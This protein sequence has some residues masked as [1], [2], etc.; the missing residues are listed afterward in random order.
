MTIILSGGGDPE[1]V[2]PIDQY[3]ADKIDWQKPVLY[4]PVA[5]EAS[6]FSYDECFEWF[7][8]TYGKYGISH[9]AMC[10][11]LST[12]QL[13]S[14]FGAVFIG[15]GNTFKLLSEIRHSGFAA[16]IRSYLKEGGV[17]YGGSAG[18]IVC[19]KTIEPAIYA[20]ENRV[21]IRDLSGLNLLDGQ[22]V[23]C[24]YD[25]ARHDPFINSLHRNLYVLYEESGLIADGL[26]V[27]PIGKPFLRKTVRS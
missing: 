6:V 27:T 20:D 26:T 24:H 11:D 18:A 7:T 16:Q 3:F 25:P 10:T 19:G 21:G 15:G 2:E 4:I 12:L 17:L 5:M 22:D 14:R 1:E 13:N 8:S 9:V 23:F